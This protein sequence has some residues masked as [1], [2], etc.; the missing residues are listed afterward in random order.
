M[1]AHPRRKA[2]LGQRRSRVGSTA[3]GQGQP[4][5]DIRRFSFRRHC[6]GSF[7]WPN[8]E[9]VRNLAVAQRASAIPKAARSALLQLAPIFR[10]IF[11]ILVHPMRVAFLTF[12]RTGYGAV[13]AG[14]GPEATDGEVDCWP[15]ARAAGVSASMACSIF[16]ASQ[17]CIGD[18][19]LRSRAAR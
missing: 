5:E 7:I 13:G 4:D 9:D 2:W 6:G 11:R 16:N 19:R 12:R 17:A 8:P 3:A 15:P 1:E 14:Q 18:I 10:Q